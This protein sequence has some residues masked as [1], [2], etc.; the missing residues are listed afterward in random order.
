MSKLYR[1][2]VS[3]EENRVEH[4]KLMQQ[5]FFNL[6]FGRHLNNLSNF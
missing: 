1:I 5:K 6:D 3:G 4:Q 2:K